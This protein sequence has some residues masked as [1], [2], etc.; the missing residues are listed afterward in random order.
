M[1]GAVMLTPPGA[2]LFPIV[3]GLFAGF[4]AYGRARLAPHRG[5]ARTSV[6]QSAG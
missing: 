4:V 5:S 2:V 3:A 1:L 6:L